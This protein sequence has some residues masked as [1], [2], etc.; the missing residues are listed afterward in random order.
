MIRPFYLLL[1]FNCY[2]QVVDDR[3]QG[4]LE[5]L[6]RQCQSYGK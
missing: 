5:N 3:L 1:V 2:I 4:P 6:E